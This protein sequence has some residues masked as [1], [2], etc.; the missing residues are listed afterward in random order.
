MKKWPSYKRKRYFT[1]LYVPD[2][3]KAPKPIRVCR[4]LVYAFAASLVVVL[5]A[6]VW[7]VSRYGDKLH[8]TY[9]LA[10][11]EKENAVLRERVN[12][13]SRD[14]GTLQRQV[15]QNFDFQK[16]ARL[17]AGLDEINEDVTEV[18]VG[19]PSFSYQRSIS[20]LD[21]T[22]HR[23]V[24]QIGEELDKLL[25]QTELQHDSYNAILQNLTEEDE[26]QKATPTIR[27]VQQGFV[28]SRFGRRM[29]PFTGRSTF[30]RGVDFSVP[31]G[32][33]IYAT[34]DGVVNYVGKWS[35][36]GLA[37]EITHGHGFITRYAHV[38]KMLVKKGQRVKRGDIVAR[39]GATGRATAAHLHYEVLKD[40][41][42]QNPLNFIL[43]DDQIARY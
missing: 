15:H 38:S 30:H 4:V 23:Q 29:D 37:V 2:E 26:L 19:G 21:D 1:F 16:K 3:N 31:K 42:H 18:G 22:M 13:F 11:L 27:P 17:L 34:A 39:V 20:L 14:L 6:C 33:A 43:T 5:V 7:A 9:R 8:E 10:S 40:G 32:T 25:R 35:G 41:K 28:S 12:S 24:T 36:F